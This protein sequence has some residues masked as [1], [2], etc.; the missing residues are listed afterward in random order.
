MVNNP[1]EEDLVAAGYMPVRE[2]E[3]EEREGMTATAEYSV[4]DGE[5]V[6]RWS[7]EPTPEDGNGMRMHEG[8]GEAHII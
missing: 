8:E 6:Q 1:T 7:Y 4:E 2:S 3:P 5:I